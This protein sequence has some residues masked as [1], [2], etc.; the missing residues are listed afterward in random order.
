MNRVIY[1]KTTE[2]CNLSCKHCF[3]EGNIPKRYYWNTEAIINWIDRLLCFCPNDYIHFELHGGEPMLAPMS[4]LQSV[5][6][7]IRGKNN[8]KLSI[9]M[10]S[11]L[12][13]KLNQEKIDFITSLDG[14]G[15]SWDPDIRFSNDNQLRLWIDNVKYLNTKRFMT[16]FISVSKGLI[17]FDTDELLLFIKDLGF[18][19]VHFERITS[20]G[21]AK[22][23]LDLFPNNQEID[24]W[25]LRLHDSV[26]RLQA[27]QWYYITSLE[28]VYSK[29]EKFQF[30]NGT[31][32][33]DCQ[34]K[35]FTINANGTIAGCPNSAPTEHYGHISQSIESLLQSSKRIDSIIKEKERNPLCYTCPVFKYCGSDCHKLSWDGDICPAPKSLMYKLMMKKEKEIEERLQQF[36]KGN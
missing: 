1:L 22:K 21:N 19:R 15:T 7:H 3:T 10:T 14:F 29:F 27:R 2:S 25:Y 20:D 35:L 32:C 33:R 31:F 26:E 6:S 36:N 9:G 28:D 8:N 11:N 18:Q 16:L 34:E 5:Y 30:C 12:V 17:T 23:N 13:Y 24:Q 4:S